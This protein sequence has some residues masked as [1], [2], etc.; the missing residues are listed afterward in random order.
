VGRFRVDRPEQRP[1]Q[2][3]ENPYHFRLRAKRAGPYRPQ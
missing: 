2:T 1:G 3:V